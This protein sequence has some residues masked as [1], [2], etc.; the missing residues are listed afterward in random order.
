VSETRKR[1]GTANR[2]GTLMT[3]TKYP[4]LVSFARSWRMQGR[5]DSTIDGY[6]YVLNQLADRLGGEAGLITATRDELE[7]Y[8]VQRLA[9]V[10]PSAVSFDVR[11]IRA[12]FKWT[13][14]EGETPL[15]PAQKLKH[16]K[17]DEPP[18]RVAT[19]HDLK[20]LVGTCDKTDPLGRRDAAILGLLA[21]GGLRRSELCVIDIGDLDLDR[22]SLAIPKTKVG[23]P[24]QVPLHPDAVAL[25]DR[26]VRARG[27]EPGPLFTT[28]TGRRITS[29]A[30]GQ[31]F[32][33]R[34]A[35]VGLEGLGTHAFRRG[36]AI[37]WLREGGSETSLRA[38]AGWTSTRM[39]G[40]YTR[41]ASEE[42]AH[43]EYRK[44]LG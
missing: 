21:W 6:V 44:I 41:M 37:R 35:M 8:V 16:P 17:V 10:S 43:D 15:N 40:T 31:M 11:A 32:S 39:V 2:Q 22:R 19:E 34:C 7:E 4:I 18:V 28:R 25:L 3:L 26:W 33:K 36:L 27:T 30:V 29:N 14:D 42:L 1:L 24:R 23:R 13:T 5:A 38:I 20:R 9:V 12:F